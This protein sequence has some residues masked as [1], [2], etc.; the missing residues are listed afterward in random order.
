MSTCHL[1]A[2]P[3]YILTLNG[4]LHV[5]TLFSIRSHEF[6]RRLKYGWILSKEAIRDVDKL[7]WNIFAVKCRWASLYCHVGRDATL[8]GCNRASSSAHL[9]LL[10]LGGTYSLLVGYNGNRATLRPEDCPGQEAD[11]CSVECGYNRKG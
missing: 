5:H 6:P 3:D 7:L 4:K 8:A 9:K 10:C 11:C 1:R 2:A